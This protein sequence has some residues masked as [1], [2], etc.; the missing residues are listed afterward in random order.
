MTPNPEPKAAP[1]CPECRKLGQFHAPDC[2]CKCHAQPA[3]QPQTGAREVAESLARELGHCCIGDGAPGNADY[4]EGWPSHDLLAAAIQIIERHFASL[5]AHHSAALR[6]ELATARYVGQVY[7]DEHIA[8]CQA[9]AREREARQAAE[10]ERDTN[11]GLYLEQMRLKEGYCGEMRAAEARE[12]ALRG[13]L[14][15]I[16]ESAVNSADLCVVCLDR[17]AHTSDCPIAIAEAALSASPA[18][19]PVQEIL[20][21]VSQELAAKVD[22]EILAASPAA[23][24]PQDDTRDRVAYMIWAEDNTSVY[25]YFEIAKAMAPRYYRATDAI[26]G[27]YNLVPR[28]VAAAPET[29]QEGKV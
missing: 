10:R 29:D 21:S 14:E 13:A 19:N 2:I 6:E 15:G 27:N 4:A 7:K 22:R 23:A 20:S 11:H 3:P 9:L 28:P 25:E 8:S 17:D 1:R 12:A 24:Q 26:M 16:I 18:E 5:E